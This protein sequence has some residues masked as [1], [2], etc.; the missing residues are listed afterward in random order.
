MSFHRH[1]KPVK[2]FRQKVPPLPAALADVTYIAL[3]QSDYDGAAALYDRLPKA[4]DDPERGSIPLAWG[5]NPNLIRNYPDIVEYVYRTRTPRDFVVADASGAGYVNP[6]SLPNLEVWRHHSKQYYHQLD[7]SISPMVLDYDQPSKQVKEAYR[8]FSPRGM[9]CIV[10]D[11]HGTGGKP[12][13]PH[14]FS[15]MPVIKMDNLSAT[16]DKAAPE[17]ADGLLALL[18][19]D[20]GAGPR[21]HY[22]RTVWNPPSLLEEVRRRVEQKSARR[23]VFVDPYA[24]FSMLGKALGL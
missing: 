16:K 9:A 2:E 11:L 1:Y 13:V 24:F 12:P 22:V 4:W 5:I 3:H 20:A 21:F 17:V 14:V 7:I 18:A 15:G 6:N 23:V 8:E 10:M 19:K